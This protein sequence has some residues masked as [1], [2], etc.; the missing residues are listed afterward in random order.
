MNGRFA[1]QPQSG[2]QRFS[3]E[4]AGELEN[5]LG[6]RLNILAPKT[7]QD[8]LRSVQEVGKFGGHKWEQLE[9]P[10]FAKPGYL[11]NLGNTAPV[12][13]TRQLI[14]IH[15]AGVFEVPEAYGFFFRM[16][17]KLMQSWLCRNGT[18]IVTVSLSSRRDIAKHLGIPEQ[19][20]LLMPEGSD[21]VDRI[22]PDFGCLS[23]FDL[24]RNRYVLVVGNLAAHKNLAALSP[25]ARMLPS[26]GV[27]LVIAGHL[28]GAAFSS[29]GLPGLPQPACY[30]GRVTDEVL[31]A[32]Y[33]NALCYVFPSFYEGYGL[34][35]MEAM[36]CGCP[37]VAADI[38][39]LRESCGDAV[40]YA[41][42]RSPDDFASKALHIFR[43]EA[44]RADLAVRGLKH[45]QGQTWR[46]AA[47]CLIGIV[48]RDL[49]SP[50][51]HKAG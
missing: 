50:S 41:N 12:S 3:A 34:P 10:R 18:T 17:Y 48:Q 11:I 51:V 45:T 13:C 19:R 22:K 4:L 26:L 33:H 47:Q 15:D 14:V 40:L 32:L 38:P 2:V 6:S 42:P 28:K 16:W 1:V 46:R 37:V 5:L 39:A 27:K 29:N 35:A 36:R 44:L 25:L 43:N 9:L 8:Y 30:V 23:E 21:H 7:G 24:Q 20:I 49:S 31:K